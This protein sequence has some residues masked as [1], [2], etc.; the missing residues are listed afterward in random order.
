MYAGNGQDGHGMLTYGMDAQF[1]VARVHHATCSLLR[2]KM[3]TYTGRVQ[4]AASK[5]QRAACATGATC[6]LHRREHTVIDPADV[7]STHHALTRSTH[8][9][10]VW[11]PG[12][13]LLF[14]SL[15][16]STRCAHGC[17]AVTNCRA[18]PHECVHECRPGSMPTEHADGAFRRSML[19]DIWRTCRQSMPTDMPT[20]PAYNRRFSLPLS[21]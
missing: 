18:A 16:R 3:Q 4:M 21:L 10:V 15:R 17:A 2:C 5:T 19:A 14:C 12:A 6:S 11:L 8:T 7:A 13:T 9:L 1:H 20:E